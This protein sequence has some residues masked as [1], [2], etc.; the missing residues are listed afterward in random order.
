MAILDINWKDFLCAE[1]DLPPDVSFLVKSVDSSEGSEKLFAAHRLLLAGCSPVFRSMFFGP[2]KETREV[3]EVED[4]TPEAFRSM[5]SFIYRPPEY[6]F[7]LQGIQC[8]QK[9]F[10]L[11]HLSDKYQILKLKTM[12]SDALASFEITNEVMIFAATVAIKYRPLF[13]EESKKMLLRCLKFIYNSTSSGGG[14]TFALIYET[15]RNFPEADFNVL[16]QL[17]DAGNEALQLQGI[18]SLSECILPN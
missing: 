13:E 4:T 17:L 2:L 1:S 16:H 14:D 5:I 18:F 3:I 7:T 9:L 15:K 11:L 6:K 12:T 8:P 10:E